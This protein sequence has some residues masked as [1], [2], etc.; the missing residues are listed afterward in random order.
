MNTYVYV[1]NQ[2]DLARLGYL[3]YDPS[4]TSAL[5]EH[6]SLPKKDIKVSEINIDKKRTCDVLVIGDSFSDQGNLGYVN[7]L[8]NDNLDVIHFDR[9]FSD[10][11]IQITVA[12][13]NGGFFDFIQPKYIVLQS[14]ERVFVPRCQSFNYDAKY[15]PEDIKSRIKFV[16]SIPNTEDSFERNLPVFKDDLLKIPLTNIEFLFKSKPQYSQTY[17]IASS[18]DHLFS[19]NPDNILVYQEDIDNLSY[20]NDS[21]KIAVC[22]AVLNKINSLLAE[23]NIQLIVVISPDKYDMFYPYFQNKEKYKKPLFYEYFNKLDKEY[24][25]VNAYDALSDEIKKQKDIYFYD[26]THWSPKGANIVA[27]EIKKIIDKSDGGRTPE[28]TQ[29]D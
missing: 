23:K 15:T 20:K 29:K 7:Y 21:A 25:Y 1:Q 10:N 8:A 17:K 12:L 27:Q 9:Y 3:Y 22:N 4:P 5:T 13:L 14:I 26:D 24:K 28:K 16:N 19:G 11:P 18:D 6:L 2:G